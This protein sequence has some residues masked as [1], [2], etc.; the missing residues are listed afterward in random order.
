M[1][2]LFNQ[3]PFILDTVWT[4][5]TIPAALQ[6]TTRSADQFRQIV[7]DAPAAAGD[8]VVITDLNGEVVLEATATAADVPVLLWSEASGRMFTLKFGKWVLAT[9]SSGKLY[10]LK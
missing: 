9:L 8:Q 1:A 4:S 5:G 6:S 7:W 10:M 2:N 3:N